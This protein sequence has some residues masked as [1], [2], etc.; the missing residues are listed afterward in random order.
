MA[1]QTEPS[2]NSA[3]D[4]YLLPNHSKADSR[5]KLRPANRSPTALSRAKFGWCWTWGMSRPQMMQADEKVAFSR[6]LHLLSSEAR[7][8]Q[9]NR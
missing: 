9:A 1:L 3:A 5:S 7:H 2:V 8:V 4:V 6:T